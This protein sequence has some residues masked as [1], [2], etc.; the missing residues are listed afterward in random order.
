MN[1]LKHYKKGREFE[2][3]IM[4]VNFDYYMFFLNHP[5]LE[6][7]NK[8]IYSKEYLI[9]WKDYNSKNLIEVLDKNNKIEKIELKEKEKIFREEKDGL[10]YSVVDEKIEEIKKEINLNN[11]KDVIGYRFKERITKINNDLK[12][13][14][15]DFSKS[16]INNNKIFWLKNIN[17]K[18]YTKFEIEAE[19]IGNTIPN[20][21]EYNK[22]LNFINHIKLLYKLQKQLGKSR[23]YSVRMIWN[24]PIS[25][26]TNNVHKILENY[27]VSEKAD[28]ERCLIYVDKNK[29]VLRIMKPFECEDIT[30]DIGNNQ[31]INSLWDAEWLK[32]LNL[33]LIFDVLIYNN[34]DVTNLPF[35]ERY[36][37]V[38]KWK[39]NNISK[40]KEFYFPN[41]KES[42]FNLSEKVYTKKYPYQ[43]DGLIYTPINDSYNKSIILKWKPVEEVTI[44][45]LIRFTNTKNNKNKEKKEIHQKVKLFVNMSKRLLEEKGYKITEELKELF[46]FIK[47]DS[48]QFP[49]YFEISPEADIELKTQKGNKIINKS[50]K[51]YNDKKKDIKVPIEDNTIIEFS[52]DKDEKD[53]IKRWKPYRLR[54][55][56]TREYLQFANEGK[57]RGDAGPNGWK[58]AE[59]NYKIIQNPVTKEMI[60]G[61][62]ELPERYYKEE[63]V[64]GTKNDTEVYK[65]NNL[66]KKHI[67]N[68]YLKDGDTILE[69]A[70]GR[71]GDLNKILNKKPKK[72]IMVEVDEI[73]IEEA[74]R[75]LRSMNSKGIEID[76]IKMDLLN[77]DIK[78]IE[79]VLK[80]EN[81]DVISCQFAIHYFMGSDKNIKNILEIVKQYLKIGG[82][83]F[84]TSYDGDIINNKLKNKNKLIYK[85]KEG[86]ILAEINKIY[87]DRNKYKE[88]DV[89]VKKIGIKHKEYLV[90]DKKI[91]KDLGKDFKIEEYKEFKIEDYNNKS[92]YS[93]NEEEYINLH[94]YIVFKRV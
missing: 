23:I 63:K 47:D 21:E 69:L 46:P 49:Y 57:Y 74:K 94:R 67:Y 14:R 7:L 35:K 39:E 45:F 93:K 91:E 9:Y 26:S 38:K 79:K 65:F 84:Y 30:K 36:Q 64:E 42:I 24:N 80:G 31:E 50:I 88:I 71:G 17:H 81:V 53:E 18:R 43:I 89:Y 40:F 58:T 25:M 73:A 11:L 29:N 92:K 87:K 13:W 68:K 85:T 78:E 59:E 75:R 34:I 51:Y 82:Y 6:T 77:P 4:D 20:K 27:S 10:V 16:I 60:F 72:I 83:F 22:L 2:I 1:A 19:Y 86:N 28:G 37:L 15:F 3:R 70:S 54:L 90:N 61:K 44:D 76:F 33:L 8:P 56:K 52:Y 66:V 48:E 62:E 12:S 55:D 5:L 32:D 41:N